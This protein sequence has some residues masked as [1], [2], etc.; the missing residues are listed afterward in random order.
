V[1]GYGCTPADI[2]RLTARQI[3]L[4]FR[5]VQDS[6]RRARRARITDVNAAFAGG[7]AATSLFR[8]LE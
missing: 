1:A 2:G 5:E 7:E 3:E 6:A 4:F 8:T